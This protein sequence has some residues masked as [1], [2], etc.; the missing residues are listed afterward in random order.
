LG[1]TT[2]IEGQLDRP[3]PQY[4][5]VKL[6][7]VGCCS[8]DYQS[9][10][11]AVTKRFQGGGTLLVA[12]TNSKLL[13]NTDTLTSWLEGSGNGG[14]GNVQDWNNLRG[15]YSLSS[16]DVPQRMVISYVLD[17]PF[18]HGKR[19]MA[20]ASG[21]VDKLVAGWGVD[22][23][24]TLQRGFP[25]K[26][27]DGEGNTLFGLGL[28]TG[29]LRP[30]VVSGCNKQGPRTVGEWFNTQCFSQPGPYN[31]GDESRVDSTLRQAGIINFDF[32][33]FKK[34]YFGPDGRFNIEFRTEFFNLFNRVQFAA[35]NTTFNPANPNFGVVSATNGNPRLVQF[36]LRFGF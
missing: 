19:F 25:L 11:V 17:L 9:L 32:A 13:S 22:G 28:G 27:S 29:N 21:V 24:T 20:D 3:F 18:G 5:D 26:I 1:P 23:V 6:A 33:A 12:Y 2:L 4:T 31:F 34:T 36:A 7:G 35:P 15:E 14:T 8:S 10:Q 30:D 16:Q